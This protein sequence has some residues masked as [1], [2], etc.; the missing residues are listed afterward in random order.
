MQRIA[1]ALINAN[2][3]LKRIEID[4][5]GKPLVSQDWLQQ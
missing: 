2:Y 3:T 4:T 5:P 1:D